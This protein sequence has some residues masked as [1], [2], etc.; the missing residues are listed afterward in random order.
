MSK[1]KTI[2]KIWKFCLLPT[3]YSGG[4]EFGGDVVGPSFFRGVLEFEMA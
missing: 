1:K 4:V 3:F 2:L